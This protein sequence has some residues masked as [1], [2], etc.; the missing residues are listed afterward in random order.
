MHIRK[1]MESFFTP[2]NP[3]EATLDTVYATV[4]DNVYSWDEVR[5][6]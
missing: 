2:Y 6:Y 1:E 3:S 4:K 5:D